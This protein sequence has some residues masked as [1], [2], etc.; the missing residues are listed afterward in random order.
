MYNTLHQQNSQ[1]DTNVSQKSAEK[2]PGI[3]T[4]PKGVKLHETKVNV[5]NS[6]KSSG[7]IGSIDTSTQQQNGLMQGNFLSNEVDK[8]C[9]VSTKDP[10][11]KLATAEVLPSYTGSMDTSTQQQNALMQGNS[12]L[13][14][15]NE[16]GKVSKNVPDKVLHAAETPSDTKTHID[17]KSKVSTE[18][19]DIEAVKLAQKESINVKKE[20]ILDLTGNTNSMD[21]TTQQQ[22]CLTQGNSS[23][24]EVNE[25]GKVS[26]DIEAVKLAQEESLNVKKESLV[27]ETTSESNESSVSSDIPLLSGDMDSDIN[28]NMLAEILN[29]EKE[30]RRKNREKNAMHKRKMINF[31]TKKTRKQQKGRKSKHMSQIVPNAVHNVH[32]PQF[33]TSQ[34][35]KIMLRTTLFNKFISFELDTGASTSVLSHDIISSVNKNYATNLKRFKSSYELTGVTG[36]SLST[37]GLFKIPL[38]VPNIGIVHVKMTIVREPNI[39][40]LG[41]D[42]FYKTGLSLIFSGDR[43][44]LSF[45]KNKLEEQEGGFIF[46]ENEVAMEPKESKYEVININKFPQGEYEAK[47]LNR[48]PGIVMPDSIIKI[49]RRNKESKVKIILGNTSMTPVTIPKHGLKIKISRLETSEVK[50]VGYKDIE[51]DHLNEDIIFSHGTCDLIGIDAYFQPKEKNPFGKHSFQIN[52]VCLK[53]VNENVTSDTIA[54]IHS[55]HS[56]GKHDL[57]KA[58]EAV[59][60]DNHVSEDE[61]FPDFDTAFH[62]I[63]HP[64]GDKEILNGELSVPIPPTESEIKEEIDKICKKYP[65]E[66]NKLLRPVLEKN[67]RLLKNAYDLPVCQE[68]LHFELK[69]PIQKN[70][71]VY[72]IKPGIAETFYST[73]QYMVYYGILR[74]AEAHES[75]G[76]PTFAIERKP[77]AD[78]DKTTFSKPLRILADLRSNN[79][80]ISGSLSAS[81]ISCL[82]IL[83]TLAQDC[84][85]LSLLDISNCFYSVPMSKEVLDTGYNNI[86]TPWGAFVCTRALSGNSIVP[87]FVTNY[88]NK[89]IFM[90]TEGVSQ[91]IS[92]VFNFYDDISVKS[93]FGESKMSHFSKL[94]LV[95]ER[96]TKA[97]FQLN[98]AKSFYCIDMEKD[99]LE[100]LGYKVSANKLE[101]TEKRKLDIITALKTPKTLK[102]LQKITGILNYV[103]TC[104]DLEQLQAVSKLSTFTKN[105]KLDWT[106]EG[107]RLLSELKSS[108]MNSTMSVLVPPRNC[109][110]ILYTDSSTHTIAGML[111]FCPLSI[112]ESTDNFPKTCQRDELITDHIETF[113]IPCEAI[114][115]IKSNV[116][117]FCSLTYYTYTKSV[118]PNYNNISKM[119]VR[120]LITMTPV[121]LQKFE[122]PEH[123][124]EMVKDIENGTNSPLSD[125]FILHC[126]SRIMGRPLLIMLNLGYKQKSPYIVEGNYD[127]LSPIL[128]S[129]TRAG[130]QLF[131]L[132][133]EYND[134]KKFSRINVDELSTTE[135]QTMFQKAYKGNLFTFGGCFGR[136]LPDSFKSSPIHNKELC[137]L[138]EGLKY[139]A[140]FIQMNQTVAVMDNSIVAH[141]LK[142]YKNRENNKLFRLGMCIGADYPSLK[143]CLCS[144]SNMKADILTR[145]FDP[146]PDKNL[147]KVSDNLPIIELSEYIDKVKIEDTEENSKPTKREK[148][149]N[150]TADTDLPETLKINY[151]SPLT[152]RYGFEGI[153]TPDNIAIET[154]LEHPELMKD[155]NYELIE[156]LLKNKETGKV[157]LP[158]KLYGPYILKE[159]VSRGHEGQIKLMEA[160]R[161]VF[162]ITNLGKLRKETKILIGACMSCISGKATFEKKLIFDSNYGNEIGKSISIDI[163]EFNKGLKISKGQYNILGILLVMD[164]VSSYTSSYYLSE[165]TTGA[166]INSLLAHFSVNKIPKVLLSDNAS[167][168]INNKFSNFLRLFN[169]RHVSSSPLHSESRGKIERNIGHFRQFSRLFR[170]Q[171]PGIRPELSYV[172]CTKFRNHNKIKGLPVTPAFLQNYQDNNYIYKSDYRSGILEDVSA[173]IALGSEVN[174]ETERI[175]AT[176]LFAKAMEIKSKLHEDRMK[177]LNKNKYNHTFT[178]GT[179][180]AIKNFDRKSKHMPTYLYEP[181]VVLEVRRKLLIL[182]SLISG[183]IRKRHVSHVKKMGTVSGLNIPK[184]LL[185]RN[186]FYGPELLEIMRNGYEKD[187]TQATKRTTRS[188]TKNQNQTDTTEEEFRGLEDSSED[189]KHV[190]FQ[191]E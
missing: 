43:Y 168:F 80:K 142:S 147:E 69:E 89:K 141:S 111:F 51:P 105:N 4:L 129:K 106:E 94:A 127:G 117:D 173:K 3:I 59:F 143:I 10:N 135:I 44:R 95:I 158:H 34:D 116:L 7:N 24:N 139:F 36:K 29:E 40:L 165:F 39:R 15:V 2:Q 5:E 112:F 46:N 120:E 176:E 179:V 118:N 71:K 97:G 82:D 67:Q 84:R 137:A 177:K 60:K 25:K 81:M 86:L 101:V 93:F 109:I 183:V 74:R 83:R 72:P 155:P 78:A 188:K 49:H 76:A 170:I 104:L 50:Y 132:T 162:D 58:D 110:N 9:E 20:K 169:V 160:I 55:V 79:S 22:N 164:N 13:N 37:V 136:R 157:F 175:N 121:L 174:A 73:L 48:P 100:V 18:K 68:E 123:F 140:S 144:T 108:I 16:K 185:L 90:D 38:Y 54:E 42:F 6:P 182:E 113:D 191:L 14:E 30:I 66:I 156:G 181:Y 125:H 178:V 23:L 122:S 146:D 32:L 171:M 35:S 8:K 184:D 64:Q 45:D 98:L 85:Y 148:S 138:W 163:V 53:C 131:G 189:E 47:L 152:L 65:P 99:S 151:V 134:Q 28:M 103:R 153:C 31:L 61:G 180:A 145:L 19:T 107:E 75:F 11:K 187:K 159:H 12:S 161:N 57:G 128:I 21:T 91:F 17:T 92:S 102:H 167:I 190:H 133:E 41:R 56:G 154:K 63:V 124:Q 149:A 33:F 1:I 150:T 87:S 96:I 172:F 119:V 26:A 62:D 126:L 70:T 166:V 77:P 114:S 115:E 27:T 130:Y 52:K 186:K 88:L